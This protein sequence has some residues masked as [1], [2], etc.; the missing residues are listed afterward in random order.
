MENILRAIYDSF[1]TFSDN[2]PQEQRSKENYQKLIKRLRKKERKLA[3]CI[4]DDKNR[5]CED[6]SFDS[7]IQGF[8]LAWM[9]TSQINNYGGYHDKTI[10]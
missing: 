5:F 7:F 8:R 1:Y 9:L 4:I 10:D 3:L 2:I 6:T